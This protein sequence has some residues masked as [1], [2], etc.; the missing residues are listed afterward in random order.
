MA[1]LV[2][3]SS[4][5]AWSNLTP[6]VRLKSGGG[7]LVGPEGL[8]VD[9]LA[10]S[11]PGHQHVLTDIAGLAN[12]LAAQMAVLVGASNSIAWSNLT[13]SVRRKTNGGL[14]EDA[15]GIYLDL[16]SGPMQAAIGNHTHTQLHDPVT[17]AASDTLLL[18]LNGQ[19]LNAEVWLAD[20]GGL[21]VDSGLAV[22]FGTGH[23]QAARGDHAHPGLGMITPANTFSLA[24]GLDENAVLSG[25][26]RCDPNPGTGRAAVS[27]GSNG[28]YL[29]LGTDPNTA[30]AG[31]HGH[32]V[33]TEATAGFMSATDK[34]SLDALV[35]A[36]AVPSF[37]APLVELAGQVSIPAAASGVN[38]Y[39]AGADKAYLSSLSRTLT[40]GSGY[41]LALAGALKALG[42]QSSDGSAG[43]T[44][45][46][47]FK[48]GNG[49]NRTMTIKNGLVVG[50][51]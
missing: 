22:D 41:D 37:A 30:A 8:S 20:L 49:A 4:S 47:S 38:G 27:V 12:A 46:Q 36:G 17:L 19:E 2:G 15:G 24:L 26:V 31:D 7:L 9:P 25:V 34:A 40:A 5:V 18:E 28:L 1:A 43:I 13:P 16:G 33:A 50:I 39:M 51:V 23:N 11:V 32:S 44:A 45:T 21:K 3:A 42:Y 35:A 6:S 14:L 48:D 10:V 29:Q